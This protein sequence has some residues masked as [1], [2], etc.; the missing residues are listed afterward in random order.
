MYVYMLLRSCASDYPKD[1]GTH[2]PSLR[3]MQ[4]TR[5]RALSVAERLLILLH[6]PG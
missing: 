3:A 5:C 2:I 1:V 4:S 6:Y